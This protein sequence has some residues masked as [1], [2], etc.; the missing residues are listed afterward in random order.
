MISSPNLIIDRIKELGLNALDSTDPSDLWLA[1]SA[2]VRP[3]LR[4]PPSPIKSFFNNL[5][6]AL[7]WRGRNVV[8]IETHTGR[9]DRISS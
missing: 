7:C 3:S 2:V 9:S 1:K 8:I 4:R 5:N 6:M